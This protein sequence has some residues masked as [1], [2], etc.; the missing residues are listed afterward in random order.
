[1][2]V[3]TD[4]GVKVQSATTL[5]GNDIVLISDSSGGMVSLDAEEYYEMHRAID[6]IYPTW[7]EGNF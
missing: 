6:L 4:R 7:N 3:D 1:M 2:K 5:E